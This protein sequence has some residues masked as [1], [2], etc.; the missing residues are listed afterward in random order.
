M[1][2]P[3]PDIQRADAMNV[4]L[5]TKH[6]NDHSTKCLVI[7]NVRQGTAEFSLCLGI[8]EISIPSIE[9]TQWQN[10]IERTVHVVDFG[11]LVY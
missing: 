11:S 10:D 8:P 2:S 4:H 1:Y 9:K 3:S 5:K 6:G 7:K